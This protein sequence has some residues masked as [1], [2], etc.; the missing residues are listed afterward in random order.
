MYGGGKGVPVLTLE[1]RTAT[2]FFLTSR[3]IDMRKIYFLPFAALAVGCSR[4]PL[5][6]GAT[7]HESATVRFDGGGMVGS[8]NFAPLD[9]STTTKA[10]AP[11]DAEALSD[12]VGRGG[13]MVGSGN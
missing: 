10:S 1:M 6:P 4:G 8:G 13:G 11:Y 7:R 3:E 2:H 5:G 9:T 12:S